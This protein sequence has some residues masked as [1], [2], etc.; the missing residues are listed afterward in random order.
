MR[1]CTSTR[2]RALPTCPWF[3]R[4]PAMIHS[5]ATSI[6]T[7]S[8]RIS[9]DLPPSSRLIL[10]ISAAAADRLRTS[11]GSTPSK[12][13]LSTP[14]CRARMRP[15]WARYPDSTFSTPGGNSTRLAA[16]PSSSALSGVSSDDSSTQVAPAAS[17]GATVQAAISKG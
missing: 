1:S 11:L 8:N 13:S 7:S 9:G 12:A 2:E 15:A 6:S 14:G 5:T 17:A 3:Q 16:S 4:Q 10:R